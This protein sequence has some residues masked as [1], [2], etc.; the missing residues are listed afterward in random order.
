[1]RE[2]E[3]IFW[4]F[5]SG[6]VL[7]HGTFFFHA[8]KVLSFITQGQN[9]IPLISVISI[10]ISKLIENIQVQWRSDRIEA[11]SDRFSHP[12]FS[13]FMPEKRYT[14]LL[15]IAKALNQFAHFI[16][17]FT[18]TKTGYMKMITRGTFCPSFCVFFISLS[19]S[20]HPFIHLHFNSRL[21][22]LESVP[23]PSNYTILICLPNKQRKKLDE[24]MDAEPIE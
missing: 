2:A 3:G 10:S 4:Q 6:N 1:M 20:I 21:D 19:F 17:L 16:C 11:Y 7:T 5:T 23:P 24:M 18:A 22:C 8:R 9:K 14:F 12:F 15:F 13:S